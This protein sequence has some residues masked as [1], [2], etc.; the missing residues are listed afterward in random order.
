M[1]KIHSHLDR[2]VEG[3][4]PH[5]GTDADDTHRDT[6]A[7]DDADDDALV[8]ESYA[9]VVVAVVLENASMRE[10]LLVL[11]MMMSKQWVTDSWLWTW[12]G[13][14]LLPLLSL[15]YCVWMLTM[16]MILCVYWAW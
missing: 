6:G 16:T 7:V 11:S 14:H 5:T 8:M 1:D 12:Q 13:K 15:L 4:V 3:R 2:G 9:A 10:I